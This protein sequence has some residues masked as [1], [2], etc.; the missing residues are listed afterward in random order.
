MRRRLRVLVLARSYPNPVLPTL[1]PWVEQPTVRLVRHVDVRVVSPV[2]WCPPLPDIG[3]LEQ[4]TRFRRVPRE[5]RRLGVDVLHPRFPS[6]PGTSLYALEARAYAAGVAQAVDRLRRA[7]PFDLVH[8]HFIYPDGAVAHRL[9]RRYGVPFVV[10]EHAPWS[11]WLDRPGVG[12]EALRAGTAAATIMAV[13]TCVRTTVHERI[14]AA[15]VE[16]IPV[17][18]D[19]DIF[20]PAREQQ[21]QRDLI[22]FVGFINY[23]KGVDVL[24]DA[25]RRLAVR[26]LPARLLLVGG[27]HYRNTRLQEE[28]LRRYAASLG[29]GDRIEFAGK[30]A[31]TQVARLMAESAVVVL[32]SRAE[33]FGAVLVEA[34]ACGT[35]VVATRCG[36]PEDIVGEE[37][38]TLVPVGDAEALADALAEVLASGERFPPARLRA[39]AAERFGLDRVADRIAEVYRRAVA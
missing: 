7:F 23:N 17:G 6:G 1:G 2:P 33:S 5:E 32:P 11:G 9:S 13:S 34:L 4:Y 29:L 12:R 16:V 26:S 27:A 24:L 22:L 37:V 39:Y 10:T 20:V 19:M 38:G 25:M 21:R 18:V 30:L 31:Q 3:P 8:A 15:Q 35:P 36:G 28:R 14:P